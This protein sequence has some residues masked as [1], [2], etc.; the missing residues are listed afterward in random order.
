MAMV[1]PNIA[2]FSPE[3]WLQGPLVERTARYL[4]VV[5]V[6]LIAHSLAQLTWLLLPSPSHPDP[7]TPGTDVLK[8]LP[9]QPALSASQITQLDL[10]G[11]PLRKQVVSDTPIKAPETNL[12][13][14]LKGVLY[15]SDPKN[16]VA[17]VA[18][19][20]GMEDIYGID[21]QVPGGAKI[22]QIYAD[23]VILLRNNHHEMLRL[24]QEEGVAVGTQSDSSFRAVQGTEALPPSLRQVRDTLLGHPGAL[25]DVVQ[26]VPVQEGGTFTGFRVHPGRD[27][28]LFQRLGLQAGDVVVAVNGVT[29]DD[30]IRGLE[31]LRELAE[32]EELNLT[33]LRGG[34]EMTIERRIE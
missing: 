2:A 14:K 23:R 19:A 20:D 30:P 31:V 3:Q 5:I 32:A 28:T 17:I 21:S 12:N 11:T 29:L 15:S 10:F 34:K 25:A 33:L 22:Q 1:S 16:A 18:T 8:P 13:V 9:P 24:P 7:L 26:A 4:T 27:R 6:L